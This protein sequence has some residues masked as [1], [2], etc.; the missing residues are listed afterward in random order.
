MAWENSRRGWVG[1]CGLTEEGRGQVSKLGGVFALPCFLHVSLNLSWSMGQVNGARQL[2]CSWSGV[3]RIPA[4]PVQVLRLVKRSSCV[5]QAIFKPLL[6]HCISKGHAVVLLFT[7][8]NTF[9][10]PFPALP[11]PGLLSFEVLDVK[12]HDCR[13]SQS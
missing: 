13:N 7:G 4:S 3:P 8:G 9:S 6:P 10:Y 2:F 12:P 1:G 11:E 5:L